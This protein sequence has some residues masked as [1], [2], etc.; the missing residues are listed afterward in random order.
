MVDLETRDTAER[1]GHEIDLVVTRLAE[2]FHDPRIEPDLRTPVQS[3]FA[4]FEHAP[5]QD[6]V[7]VFV[8]RRVRTE[9][10]ALATP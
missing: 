9:L 1:V 4:R 10:R 7:P 5:V 6:F 8:E 2:R 3:E